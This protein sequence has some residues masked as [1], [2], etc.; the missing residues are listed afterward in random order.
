MNG[1]ESI[2]NCLNREVDFEHANLL[3]DKIREDSYE[4]LKKAL[5]DEGSTDL[6]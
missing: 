3:L 6:C 5:S 1:D 4:Y 2:K